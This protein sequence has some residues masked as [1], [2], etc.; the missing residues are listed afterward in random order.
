MN[1]NEQYIEFKIS[2][3]YHPIDA[4]VELMKSYDPN[5]LWNDEKREKYINPSP[6]IFAQFRVNPTFKSL[7]LSPQFISKWFIYPSGFTRTQM[8]FA[9]QI[10]SVDLTNQWI[11]TTEFKNLIK[12]NSQIFLD[13][14]LF[15]PVIRYAS[16]IGSGFL[17]EV[18]GEQKPE[19]CGTYYFF[20]PHYDVYLKSNR[21]MFVPNPDLA[22]Y[23]L[24]GEDQAS[25]N[26]IISEKFTQSLLEH[27][28]QILTKIPDY[29]NWL[30]SG[31]E[32]WK[33]GQNIP[34]VMYTSESIEQQLSF[35][36]HTKGIDTIVIMYSYNTFGKVND[37]IIDTR[38][39]EV[40][41]KSLFRHFR[42]E[43]F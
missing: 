9:G 25:L 14:S 4:L 29:L 2:Q 38:N 22:Y 5:F 39:R 42:S 34:H 36:A 8:K 28:P 41:Y 12:S 16:T 13:R 17:F 24:L 10:P 40:S 19:H 7:N 43:N 26:T 37:E 32:A 21:T 15:I 6:H 11:L 30:K 20:E 27:Y 1:Q 31:L 23:Y 18:H 3:G 35:L 33:N